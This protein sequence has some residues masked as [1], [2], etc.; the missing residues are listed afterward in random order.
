M[1]TTLS[2]G[3]SGTT[4]TVDTTSAGGPTGIQN[5][6]GTSTTGAGATATTSWID[7]LPSQ[8]KEYVTQKGF[9]D[10]AAIVDSY[11]NLETLLGAPKD[12]LMKLPENMSDQKSMAE[13]YDKLGRPKAPTE[14][15]WKVPEGTQANPEFTKFTQELFH[16]V[17][18][19]KAQ[20]E[21]LA[22][23]WNQFAAGN[24]AQELQAKQA[25]LTTEKQALTKE[26]GAAVGD[27]LKMCAK[28]AQTFGL[29]KTALDKL[30]SALGYSATM[31]FLHQIGTKVGEHNFVAGDSSAFDGALT[32]D[33]ALAQINELKADKSWVQKYTSGDRSARQQ[34]EKLM[35]FAYPDQDAVGLI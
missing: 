4:T 15:S 29:D 20:G 5:A 25:Q 16:K 22:S 11:R 8:N 3:A 6:G 35:R 32:P 19:S 2:T 30:E 34:M 26:W 13:I 23:E 31:K 17:G 18:L 24:Q 7:G 10:P 27:N 28:A 1:E 21:Q 9:K 33:R 12:R 14:Y